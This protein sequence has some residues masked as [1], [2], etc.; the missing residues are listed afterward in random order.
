[1][2]TSLLSETKWSVLELDTYNKENDLL[3]GNNPLKW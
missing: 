1:M 3:L 2:T